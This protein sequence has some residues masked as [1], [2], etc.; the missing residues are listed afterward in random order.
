MPGM[1]PQLSS[2]RDDDEGE[3]VNPLHG[4]RTAASAS[5]L[6]VPAPGPLVAGGQGITSTLFGGQVYGRGG[7]KL[8]VPIRCCAR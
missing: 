8:P 3:A 4:P 7:V 2:L 1:R 6:F 5:E